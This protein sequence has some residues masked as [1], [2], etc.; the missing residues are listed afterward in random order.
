MM[1]APDPRDSVEYWRRV[2]VRWKVIAIGLAGAEQAD[3]A[4]EVVEDEPRKSLV[5]GCEPARTDR[6]SK[7][8]LRSASLASSYGRPMVL[9]LDVQSTANI[10]QR[11]SSVRRLIAS[12]CD[13]FKLNTRLVQ[14]AGTRTSL[15]LAEP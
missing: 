15:H 6:M 7:F 8:G 5:N 4:V 11:Q 13:T 12:F 1:N 10:I 2:S 9:A 14:I 3:A